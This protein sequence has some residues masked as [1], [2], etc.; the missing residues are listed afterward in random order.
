[1]PSLASH[2]RGSGASIVFHQLLNAQGEWNKYP[3]EKPVLTRL[4]MHPHIRDTTLSSVYLYGDG[5]C[6]GTR[7][8]VFVFVCGEREE[9]RSRRLSSRGNSSSD[10][11]P[12]P[13]LVRWRNVLLPSLPTAVSRPLAI[14]SLA[15][16]TYGGRLSE[17]RRSVLWAGFPPHN[18]FS[19][20]QHSTLGSLMYVSSAFLA[21]KRSIFLSL[22]RASIT[23]RAQFPWHR[24]IPPFRDRYSSTTI[25]W[26]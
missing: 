11:I 22:L 16:H 2:L 13:F 8:A 20:A 15:L 26:S 5:A 7:V 19:A 1:M 3:I 14:S 25:R 18:P 17:D 10:Q 23:I 4:A 9:R 12:A 24:Y 6:G 21:G